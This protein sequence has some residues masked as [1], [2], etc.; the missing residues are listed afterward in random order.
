MHIVAPALGGAT[1][2]VSPS[3]VGE[4]MLGQLGKAVV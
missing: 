3:G 4:S 2:L 1:G